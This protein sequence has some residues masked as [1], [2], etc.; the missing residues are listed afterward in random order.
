[1]RERGRTQLKSGS[2]NT[3]DLWLN[4]HADRSDSDFGLRISDLKRDWTWNFA[5]LWQLKG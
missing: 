2:D 5:E 4:I 1:V 3:L